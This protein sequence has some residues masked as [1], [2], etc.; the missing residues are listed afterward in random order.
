MPALWA[1]TVGYSRLHLGV[2]YPSDVLGGM[3]LGAGT[4]F[5]TFKVNKWLNNYHGKRHEHQ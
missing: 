3:I 4:D 2:H 1:G 5:L